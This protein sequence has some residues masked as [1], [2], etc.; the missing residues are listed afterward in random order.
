[1]NDVFTAL[2]SL[3]IG[4]GIAWW[5]FRQLSAGAMRTHTGLHHLGG[6]EGRWVKRED[7]PVKYWITIA[8]ESIAAFVFI[9]FAI[10][11]LFMK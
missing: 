8:V 1:M 10:Q 4:F 9:F 3:A 7:A 5:V 2:I 6:K 11:V